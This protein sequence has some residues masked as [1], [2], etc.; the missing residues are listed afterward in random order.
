MRT[1]M[2][3]SQNQLLFF[4]FFFDASPWLDVQLSAQATSKLPTR[5][6]IFLVASEVQ[7]S[8]FPENRKP[9]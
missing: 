7:E 6:P 9:S 8:F 5:H 3:C 4:F 2:M 1:P